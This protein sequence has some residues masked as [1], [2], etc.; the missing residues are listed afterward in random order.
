MIFPLRESQRPLFETI[1]PIVL[2]LCAVVFS[3]LYFKKVE[4]GFLTESIKLGVVWFLIS[5]LIDLLMFSWGPMK[6]SFLDYLSDIGL[7]YL[8]YP[9]VTIGFGYLL[10]KTKLPSPA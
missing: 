7:T 8:I 1:M 6:M 9:S 2:T 5:F 4:T 10:S 3:N